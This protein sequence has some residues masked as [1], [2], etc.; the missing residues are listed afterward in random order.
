MDRFSKAILA[1]G[2]LSFS[3]GASALLPPALKIG[4]VL[5]V[6]GEV[7]L[8]PYAPS[9]P[10][11]LVKEK[12]VLQTNGTYATDEKGLLVAKLFEGTSLR[13]SPDSRLALEVNV[14]EKILTVFL[15]DGSLKISF[16]N[17]ANRGAIAKVVVKSADMI[18][19]S[20][21]AKLS[22]V[23]NPLFETIAVY[24][25]KG[26]ATVTRNI[27]QGTPLQHVHADEMLWIELKKHEM[28]S[29]QRISRKE[30][31]FLKGEGKKK[32]SPSAFN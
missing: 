2:C 21:E 30:L 4:S 25:E 17:K 15:F 28:P 24:M 6:K 14:P 9:A 5:Q 1:L 22:I 13:L 8:V 12:D 19:E 7:K 20:A 26:A 3:L 27:G 23:R 11:P 18:L 29:P 10:T 31:K 32:K 16:S